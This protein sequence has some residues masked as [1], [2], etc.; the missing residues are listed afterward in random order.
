MATDPKRQSK[1]TASAAA[2]NRPTRQ[3]WTRAIFVLLGIVLL[4][5]G[6]L[7]VQLVM[8]QIVQTDDWQRRATEQQLSDNVISPHR[9]TIYDAN[10]EV[11]AERMQVWTVIMDPNNIDEEVN[12]EKLADELSSLLGVDRDK[13]YRQACK[14]DSM[15]EVVKSKIERP[16]AEELIAWVEQNELYGVFRLTTDYKRT[17]PYGSL[18]SSVLGFT[19]AENTG[20][21]GLEA[22]Y[23]ELL[24]GEAGR[25]VTA[26]NGWGNDMPNLL[27]YE[28]TVDAEDGHSLVLSIDQTIQHFAEKHLEE[29]VANTGAT[30]RAVAIVQDVNTGAILAMATKGDFD[31]NDPFTITDPNELTALAEL[32]GTEEEDAAFEAAQ[33]KQWTNKAV[34]EFYEPGSVFKMFT[35]AMALEEGIITE[36]S[37]FTC[38]GTQKVADYNIDCHVSPMSHGTQVL[39]EAISNSCNPAFIQ[40]GTAVG[41]D[42]FYEYY[43]GFGF[44]E[45]TDIDMLGEFDVSEGF[46]HSR[47]E[48]NPVELAT[49]SMGQTFKVTPLQ[50][51]TAVSAIANGGQ[52]LQP[53]VVQQV[54]DGDGNVVTNTPVTVKRQVISE[55][56]AS[57]VAR[58]LAD[59]VNSGGGRN[60]YVAGYRVAGKTGTSEKTEDRTETGSNNVVASFSGFAP[61][62]DPQVAI[63]VMIDEP[64]CA[65]RYG[66]TIAAP[67]A[68]KILEET[69]PYLGVEPQ[70]TAEEMA[71]L[72]RNTPP[73]EGKTIAEA[74]AAIHA[75]GL[76]VRVEGSGNTVIKQVPE[77]G[78]SIPAEG[79]VVLYTDQ[80]SLQSQTTTV[81]DFTGYSVSGASEVA[82]YYDLNIQLSGTNL[83]GGGALAAS[84]SIAPGT[85][86]PCG[87]IVRVEFLYED[88][89]E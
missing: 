72:S 79:R 39:G 36:N 18:L 67:V 15:Y 89:I 62:D 81:P 49:S 24:E 88:T 7:L 50:M 11:L 70:Y 3:M 12:R 56:T 83:E 61:A 64:Q 68:K 22:E 44:T 65:N 86:V 19:G 35:T 46:Y 4:A 2:K 43:T 28:K 47:D 33:I 54:L 17:Y 60:A 8:L 85:E 73:V 45:K 53:Y 84:Q 78:Q 80:S 23:N 51:I 5:F 16:L 9:G 26:Q 37:T 59:A 66:G 74:E 75:A 48:L 77:A 27:S 21:Y 20:L 38:V 30:N 29:A 57:R 40:I 71:D 42:L 52:L 13:L 76:T 31:P 1:K 6:A 58:L 34:T 32:A 82:A 14:T 25:I 69:L 87:T 10:M 41:R 63:L 55:D